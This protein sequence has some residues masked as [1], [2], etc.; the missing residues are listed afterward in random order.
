[1][2]KSDGKSRTGTSSMLSLTEHAA[3]FIYRL[4]VSLYRILVVALVGTGI[5][6]SSE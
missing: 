3:R 6:R 4:C 1:V 2:D 5:V